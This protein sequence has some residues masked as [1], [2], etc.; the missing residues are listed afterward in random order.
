M[1]YDYK[2]SVIIPC[3][4]C[5][6]F[7]D[8]TIK[9]LI[10]Q[11]FKFSDIQVLLINDGSIDNTEKICKEYESK[12]ENIEYYK[13]KNSGVSFARNNGIDKAKG[14]YIL[15]LDSDDYLS[16]FSLKNLYNFFERHY[17]EVDLVT[18]P[19]F[20]NTDG[21]ISRRKNYVK[22][23]TGIYDLEKEYH[24]NQSTINIMIKNDKNLPRFDVNM[25]LAEDQ[26]F[27][28]QILLK[29]K[30]IGLV[31]SAIYFYR[32]SVGVTSHFNNMYFC[33][34]SIYS[35]FE[36]L[37]NEKNYEDKI[38]PKFIMSNIVNTIGWRLSSDQLFANHFEGKEKDKMINRLVKILNKIDD[39]IIST[40][41]SLTEIQQ[42]YLFNLKGY[43]LK[44]NITNEGYSVLNNN[45]VLLSGKK[46]KIQLNEIK[47]INENEVELLGILD[48]CIFD[49]KKPKVYLLKDGKKESIDLQLS[50]MGYIN[51]NIKC[52][53]VYKFDIRVDIKNIKK[54]KLVINYNK[55]NLQSEIY[56]R[57]LDLKMFYS[58]NKYLK[59]IDKSK[60]EV[61][62]NNIF[63]SIFNVSLSS[64]M[65]RGQI[66]KIYKIL[67]LLKRN[68]KKVW[69]YSDSAGILDNAYYQ[70]KHDITK[71][72][73]IE[74]YYVI[75]ESIDN[76]K[77]KL[78]EE[79]LKHTIKFRTLKQKLLFLNCDKYFCSY[80]NVSNYSP[81]GKSISW[82]KDIIKHEMIYMQHGVL[83][84]NLKKMY[85]KELSHISKVVISSNFEKENFVENYGFMKDD[86]IPYGMPRL[87]LDNEEVECKN[88]ILIALSW[89]KYLIGNIINGK[90]S[91]MR[92]AFI[93]SDYYKKIESLLNNKK[94]IK[95][96]EDN[97]LEIDFKPHPIFKC[98]ADLFTSKSK[99]INVNFE[100]TI[101]SE[102]KM[103]IT[104]FS[105]YQF[106]YIKYKRPIAYFMPDKAE[107]DAGL[108]TYRQLDLKYED[109]FGNLYLNE[110]ELID[111]IIR[112]CN[113][114][115]KP[116]EKYL[117]RMKLF[118]IDND[119]NCC[120]KI[121]KS[122]I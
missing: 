108:H 39:D 114:D 73:G 84:A 47:F 13:Q 118:Y 82:Y 36:D 112:L 62:N 12:Y 98:Y 30:K 16:R 34:E 117:K 109:A 48:T 64:K 14:K 102:Y 6:K 37:L 69:L 70:F 83:H 120:E 10:K 56:F 122:L 63:K 50:T 89:R 3:Y 110:N 19:I 31:K 32:K 9:S 53:N 119:S 2:I 78:S 121:Y 38:I 4:N 60:I 18:Y 21:R 87:F 93:D 96:I 71:D 67:A 29:K 24:F 42:Y 115:F 72:D 5:E 106:D 65:I 68:N 15:F 81:F 11:N 22:Y 28:T 66:P 61:R 26:K 103:F 97:N 46:V 54:L 86:L 51:P 58:K 111:E 79:E 17:N 23:K 116:D 90:R 80:S 40:N 52:A 59:I 49:N 74:R 44:F 104:D 95:F 76:L 99:N 1:I 25:K 33:Y 20:Y 45:K 92:K 7:I 8:K 85:A 41:S 88:K 94:L 55:S 105:S 35:Y 100:K 107:F 91:Q 27:N 57:K 113:N 43:K 77:S 75:Y 101:L